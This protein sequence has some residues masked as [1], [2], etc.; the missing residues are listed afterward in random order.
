MQSTITHPMTICTNCIL[1]ETFP[2]VKFDSD[3]TCNHCRRE[4]RL[5]EKSQGKKDEYREKL[6]NLIR[7]IKDKAP[8]YDA[9]MAYSGGKDSTYTL[10]PLKEQYDIRIIA[11]TFDNH[12]I[13]PISQDNIDTVTDSLGV[14]SLRV[15]PPWP[16]MKSMFR[17]TAKTDIFPTPTL[18]R[19]SSICT[20]CI[21]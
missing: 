11:L 15:Q 2:G 14:D 6:T 18:L 4:E 1:P 7:E 9:I 21:G 12:F 19:A 5:L 17:C 16:I 13:S 20:S 8:S 10:K 3:G